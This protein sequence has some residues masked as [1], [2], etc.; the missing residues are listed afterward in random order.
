MGEWG[1]VRISLS[2]PRA[3]KF[4]STIL[5][6]VKNQVVGVGWCFRYGGCGKT[7]IACSS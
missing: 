1:K 4:S 5:R 3:V 7:V 2:K 6:V